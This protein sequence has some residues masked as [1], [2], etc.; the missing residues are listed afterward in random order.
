MAKAVG[1]NEKVKKKWVD[2]TLQQEW[3]D[4]ADSTKLKYIRAG[5]KKK[6]EESEYQGS[7]NVG[8]KRGQADKDEESEVT[9]KKTN[10]RQRVK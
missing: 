2:E 3:L 10:K 8:K 6:E 5:I 7:P 9:Q 4:F 1:K